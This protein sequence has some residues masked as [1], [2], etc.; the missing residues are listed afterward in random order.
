MPSSYASGNL[1]FCTEVNCKIPHAFQ[2]VF[3][4]SLAEKVSLNNLEN[5][6]E[7]LTGLELTAKQ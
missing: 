1:L 2:P 5:C 4:F 6:I 3:S 7:K